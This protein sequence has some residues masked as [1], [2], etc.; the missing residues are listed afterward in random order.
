MSIHFSS[1][2]WGPEDPYAFIP[3]R[4]AVKRHPIAWMPFGVGPRNCVGMRFAIMELKI[5][6]I[7]L[8]NEYNILPGEKLN[9]CFHLKE[10]TVI[11][12]ETVFVKLEKRANVL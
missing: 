11:H 5:C 3:E 1:D 6:L 8:L 7:R 10:M 12:P 4:H 9:E 2:L